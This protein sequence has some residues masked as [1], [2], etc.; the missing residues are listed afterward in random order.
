MRAAIFSGPLELEIK[1]YSLTAPAKNELLIKV[2]ACGVCG[3]DFHIFRGES[4][5]RP[6]V[7]TGHEYVGTIVEMGEDVKEFNIGDHIAVDPNIYCGEC[8]Y[9]KNG[10]INFCS[11]LKALGVSV[12]GGFADYSLVPSSQAYL[13]PK[14]FS[15]SYAAFAEPLSCCIR[16][17]DQAA[18]KLG[19]SVAIIG[20]GAIGLLMLQL[21][22]ISGAGKTIIIEPI[23]EKRAIA[24]SLGAEYV[25]DSNYTGM[26]SQISDFTSG[27]PDVVIECAGNSRAA[28]LAVN[29]PKRG[30]RVILFGLSGKKETV[31]INLQDFFLKEL[32]IKGSLLNPFTF[33]RSVEL[34]VSKKIQVDK[35]QTKLSPLEELKNILSSPGKSTII[36]H[37]ITNTN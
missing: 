28:E 5:A 32:S 22:K 13:I 6:P 1:E 16:G 35:L 20:A 23:A 37:Q 31:N 7:I 18:V 2:E 4:Y 8:S 34:L 24:A 19:E 25:F 30:G 17:I 9:C 15:F 21:A 33:S 3:T 36:K 26:A 12:N 14:D 11:N 29:L 27:G 10:K